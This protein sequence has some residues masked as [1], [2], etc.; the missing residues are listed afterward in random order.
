MSVPALVGFISLISI[1]L[2]VI[3]RA[4]DFINSYNNARKSDFD[5][6]LKSDDLENIGSYFSSRFGKVSIQSYVGHKDTR[7][8]V[9]KIL[10]KLSEYTALAPEDTAVD[11]VVA[12]ATSERPGTDGGQLEQAD[13]E[14]IAYKELKPLESDP[15]ALRSALDSFAAGDEWN[16]LARVRRDLEAKVRLRLPGGV[17]LPL[18]KAVQF[19]EPPKEIH[20]AY[21]DFVTIAN[22]AIHG[23]EVPVSRAISALNAARPVYTW[24]ETIPPHPSRL[25]PSAEEAKKPVK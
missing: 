21:R 17:R 6:A 12:K 16:A 8:R 3:Y 2:L 11:G 25:L 19:L 1:S 23:I 15:E 24:L 18:A 22:A 14:E 20:A 9:D 10:K 4:V 13:H 7:E 5:E